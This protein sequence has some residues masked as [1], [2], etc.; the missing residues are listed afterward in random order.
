[1]KRNLA[2]RTFLRAIA[3]RCAA[4]AC[5]LLFAGAALAQSAPTANI[6]AGQSKATIPALLVSDIH[7]EPFWDPAR[8]A[9]LATAPVSGWTAILAA[10]PSPDRE[11][12]F[13]ALQQSCH[14]RGADTSFALYESS[15]KAMRAHA[16]GVGFVTVSGDL[17]SHAFQCKYDALFP[18]STPEA[19]HT[20]VKKTLDYV[21]DELYS[22]FPGVP[23][24][25]ALGNNDS[26]CG[27]Y[28]LDAHS[29]FLE[30]SGREVT[31][32]FPASERP[33]AQ[34]SFAAG[35]YYSVSLPAPIKN[36]RLLVL[37]DIFMADGFQTC[38]GKADSTAADAQLAWLRRQL[39][40][41][42]AHQQ[43]VWV[44]GHIPPGVDLH[45]T[46]RRMAGV[47]SGQPPK[48]FLSSEK[49]AN[50]LAG[51]GD[52]V[53]LAIFAHTHMDEMRLLKPES[54]GGSPASVN[55]VE[56]KSAPGVAVK[57]VPSI[58]PINGNNPSF[59]LA[60]VDPSTA[61]LVD[62][63]VFTASNQTGVDEVW[64]EEYD[65]ARSFHE[66]DFSSSSV[67]ELIR[68]FAADPGAK[69]EASQDYIQDFSTGYLSPV[70]Q[71]FWPQY[72][73]TLSNVSAQAFRACVCPAAR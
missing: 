68:G 35:G 71:A 36:A 67:S 12:R 40:E 48:M 28:Q 53:E 33:S 61:A 8:A 10:A 30:A 47:C 72:V 38:S 24:Y 73:C 23:V 27:D 18:H 43:K 60:Q 11:Q 54:G 58:S 45:A 46:V 65:F 49:L 62:Y 69:T 1:M 50:L 52:V 25:V 29:E 56:A 70:L 3:G 44:M 64:K 57:M 26:D 42:R 7:F 16:A 21:V 9:Q 4:L 15:L 41:A 34:A 20:F 32:D 63:K 17:I 2:A 51:Y 39:D 37:N 5:F 55:G 14:A 13:Q 19:L 6:G 31:K 59:T 66:A 22:S